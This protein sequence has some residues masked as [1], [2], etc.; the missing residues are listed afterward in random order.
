MKKGHTLNKELHNDFS[1]LM[2]EQSSKID[3][4]YPKGSFA[5]LFWQEQLKAASLTDNRQMRWHPLIIRWCINMK[6]LS[7]S[8]YHA[9]RTAGFIKLPSERTLRDYTHYFK[10]KAG[11]QVEVLKQLQEE[12]KV[13][14][15]PGNKQF[16]GIIIDEMKIREGLVYDKTTGEVC[17]YCEIGDINDELAAL[18][19]QCLGKDTLQ[20]AKYMLVVMVRGILFKLEF[21]FAHFAC[22]DLTG[23]QIF[24]IVWEAIRLVESIGLKVLFCYC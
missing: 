17:G 8:T 22:T 13:D 24:P 14:E 16:C 20:I 19:T 2:K 21:A 4:T 3:Q 18:Q 23:E 6:L 10:Q 15:L 9:T 1:T 12:S 7:S 5:H 11:Y